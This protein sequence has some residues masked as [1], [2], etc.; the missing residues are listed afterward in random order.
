MFKVLDCVFRVCPNKVKRNDC[1]TCVTAGMTLTT[2]YVY[3]LIKNTICNKHITKPE[4][5]LGNFEVFF[6]TTQTCDRWIELVKGPPW[7]L[8]HV[9][10][11][12]AATVLFACGV[13]AKGSSVYANLVDRSQS[14]EKKNDQLAKNQSVYT[15]SV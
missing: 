11:D 3:L 1:P 2:F 10:H 4:S 6:R 12:R 8:L 9:S 15:S 14:E 13:P 5:C 7:G